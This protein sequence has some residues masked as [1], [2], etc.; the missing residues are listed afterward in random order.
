MT[1]PASDEALTV[2]GEVHAADALRN[3]SARHL[4]NHIGEHMVQGWTIDGGARTY[5]NGV[6]KPWDIGCSESLFY[7]I[8]LSILNITG[9]TQNADI[10]RD[11]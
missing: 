8:S 10:E 7:S 2:G 6:C 5:G 9:A 1:V 4:A 3:A 11:R